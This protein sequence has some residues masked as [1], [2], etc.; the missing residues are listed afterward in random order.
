MSKDSATV[1]KDGQLAVA[2]VPQTGTLVGAASEIDATALVETA[3]GLQ[4]CVKTC[5]VGGGG[6]GGGTVDQTYD[7]TSTNAQSGTA[8]AEAVQPALKNTATATDSLTILG[9]AST[10]GNSVN[11]GPGS[12]VTGVS[13]SYPCCVAIG[14]KSSATAATYTGG[15]VAVGAF[16]AASNGAIAIGS[17]SNYYSNPTQATASGSIAIGTGGYQLQCTATASKA[18]AIGSGAN[19]Q[20]AEAI[21]L[22]TGDN[23]TA[24]SFQVFNYQMLDAN[25]HIP[26]ERIYYPQPLYKAYTIVGNDVTVNDNN[27]ASGFKSYGNQQPDNSYLLLNSKIP[28]FTIMEIYMEFTCGNFNLDKGYP[29][30]VN[31]ALIR[32]WYIQGNTSDNTAYYMRRWNGTTNE[33]GVTMLSSGQTYKT[34]YVF[35]KSSVNTETA[36]IMVNGSWVKQF[37]VT[38]ATDWWTNNYFGIGG[39]YSYEQGFDGSINLNETAIYLDGNCFF[40]G[41]KNWIPSTQG[42][43]GVQGYDATKTQ[44]LKNVNGTLTWVDE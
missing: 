26:N 38:S 41:A 37:E 30:F 25:G 6:G 2:T 5:E 34:K 17:K 32:D 21:Q 10:Y 14:S 18:I 28:S 44:V 42:I 1:I 9:T 24:N 20:A 23:Q 27:I 40:N 16:A 15:S 35:N 13:N 36:Y 39:S 4:L 31:N 8:V 43:T 33:D 7:P 29:L 12:S 3:D 11:I 22:G 19:A